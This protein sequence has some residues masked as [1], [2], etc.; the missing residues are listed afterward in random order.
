MSKGTTSNKQSRILNKILSLSG[1]PF[2]L[3]AG[4]LLIQ[5]PCNSQAP[6]TGVAF[7]PPD[8]NF[9]FGPSISVQ[10]AGL[11]IGLH[12]GAFDRQNYWAA[13]LSFDFQPYEKT[14][15]VKEN[16]GLH[17]Q[18]KEKRYLLGIILDKFFLPVKAGNNAIGIYLDSDFG[19]SFGNYRG[20]TRKPP[21]KLIIFPG[22][23]LGFGL[24]NHTFLKAGV[25][26]MNNINTDATPLRYRVSLNI[27]PAK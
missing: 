13:K 9:N 27:I 1:L 4:T 18:F 16:P 17:Y 22:G 2:W 24:G 14:V 8:M 5:T 21:D 6:N 19:Y 3:L 26:W 15:W 10:P 20:T 11:D 25:Q 23:G 7:G 12:A